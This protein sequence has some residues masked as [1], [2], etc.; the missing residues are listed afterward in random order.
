MEANENSGERKIK[1]FQGERA[2][3]RGLRTSSY[4]PR[5]PAARRKDPLTEGLEQARYSSATKVWEQNFH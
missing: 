4:F 3:A 5:S 2:G 1:R